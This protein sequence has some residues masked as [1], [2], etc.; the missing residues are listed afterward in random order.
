MLLTRYYA[1][2]NL[3]RLSK[4]ILCSHVAEG[5][6][7][8]LKVKVGSLKNIFDL[9]LTFNYA[10]TY[11]K[12]CSSLSFYLQLWPLAVLQP[13][14]PQGC[15]VFNLKVLMFWMVKY[16]VKSVEILLRS[17]ISIQNTLI[18]QCSAYLVGICTQKSIRVY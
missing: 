5:N 1:I 8:P 13:L 18:Y 12:A 17:Y 9:N 10:S 7:E 11:G 14:E 3:W 15:K 6:T 2:I 4:E 16:L